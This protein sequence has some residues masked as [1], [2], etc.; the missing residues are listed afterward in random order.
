[1]GVSPDERLK[2]QILDMCSF[3]KMKADKMKAVMKASGKPKEMAN[4][5][6]EGYDFFRKGI[7]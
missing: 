3:E 5:F 6:K 2:E 4:V 1:L 7:L